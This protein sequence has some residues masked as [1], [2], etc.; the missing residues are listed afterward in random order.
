MRKLHF[1]TIAFALVAFLTNAQQV[2]RE[3]VVVEFHTTFVG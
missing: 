3:K 2:Q 1:L